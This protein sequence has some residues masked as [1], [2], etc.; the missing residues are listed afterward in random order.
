MKRKLI[1]ALEIRLEHLYD[2]LNAVNQAKDNVPYV[3]NMVDQANVDLQAF[4]QM[5]EDGEEFI[6]PLTLKEYLKGNETIKANLPVPTMLDSDSIRL[7]GVISTTGSTGAY[8]AIITAGKVD[9]PELN[10]WS[11]KFRHPFYEIIQN[12]SRLEIVTEKLEVLNPERVVELNDS[13]N[14]FLAFKSDIGERVRAATC[15]R[16]LIEHYRGD[17]FARARK[18]P[19]ENIKWNKMA[20][21]LANNNTS[22][23]AIDTLLNQEREWK[24]LHDQLSKIVHKQK[25]G[26]FIDLESLWVKLVDHLF[27]VLGLIDF[28]IK[29]H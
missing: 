16:N 20:L 29:F 17:L 11:H 9:D 5:P 3:Q 12:Q 2:W 4:M 13:I 21:R 1:R 22:G 26:E 14:A 15:M 7:T 10:Q 6:S 25:P 23:V 19:R 24:N 28:S 27:I 8:E 18:W